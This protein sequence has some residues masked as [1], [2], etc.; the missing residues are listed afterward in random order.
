MKAQEPK[1][2][3]KRDIFFSVWIVPFVALIVSGWFLYQYYAKI[4]PQI[5]IEFKNSGALKE[6]QSQ[7]RFRDVPIGVIQKIKLKE[8][9][10]HVLIIATMDKTVKPFLNENTRFWIVKPRI[11]INGISGLDT[12]VS[13]SYIQMYG[14]LGYEEKRKFIGLDEP[15]IDT[16]NQKGTLYKLFAPDSRN[17]KTGSPVF[18]KKIEVGELKRSKLNKDGSGVDFEIFIKA[19]YDRF[20]KPNSKFWALDLV[21]IDFSNSKINVDVAPAT[22]VIRGGIAFETTFI[23]DQNKTVKKDH[24]FTLFKSRSEALQK[25]LGTNQNKKEYFEMT[26]NE[27]ISKLNI[28][29]LVDFA[30]FSVG[31]VADIKSSY[32]PK[33]LNIKSNILVKIDT[34]AFSDKKDAKE[35][36]NNLKEAVKK[37]LRAKLSVSNP[38][39]GDQYIELVFTK[40]K[41]SSTLSKNSKYYTFPTIINKKSG[42]IKDMEDILVKIKRLQIEPILSKVD[43]ILA[44]NKKPINSLLLNLDKTTASLKSLTANIDDITSQKEFKK[45]PKNIDKSI[46]ELQNSLKSLDTLLKHSNNK[47]TK[48]ISVS[49]KNINEAAKSLQ[50]VL[51]KVEKKPNS[52]IMGD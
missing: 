4:G 22:D 35:G 1:I 18:Y 6:G 46:K 45:L 13:G 7:I 31:K 41:N 5:E 20:V 47:L 12:L 23:Y 2:G 42:I 49:L 40:D 39:F 3:K 37:G 43:D 44:Q 8:D 34:S 26:F 33:E 32:N 38:L 52:L 27:S 14:K 17:L 25:Y 50:R 10:D 51:L 28:G 21:S 9:N 16:T 48:E 36:L 30:G 29:S 11:D 24:I 19:P 15:Y